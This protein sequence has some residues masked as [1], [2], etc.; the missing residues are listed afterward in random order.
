M[1]LLV[2]FAAGKGEARAL[3]D[4]VEC[5]VVASCDRVVQVI[6]TAR[7]RDCEPEKGFAEVVD[8]VLVGE[9]YAF[10]D[11]VPEATCDF[12]IAGCDRSPRRKKIA[13][14]L[15]LD[16][17]FVGF[18]IIESID[19]PVAVAP[20]VRPRM[21]AILAGGIGVADYIQPVPPPV[22]SIVP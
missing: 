14:Q 4:A 10:V 13:C 7:T 1:R 22:F 2:W 19:N 6:M 18:V 20:R 17:I 16:E 9:V 8:R 21:V 11:I 15:L 12:Q 5:V 3:Q